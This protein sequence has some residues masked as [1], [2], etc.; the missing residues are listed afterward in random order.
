M[1]ILINIANQRLRLVTNVSSFIA[2]TR[3][4]IRFVFLVSKEME[5]FDITAQFIQNG[6]LY[7]ETLDTDNSV[8]L[9]EEIGVG[10]FTLTLLG[11]SGEKRAV[12]SSLEFTVKANNMVVS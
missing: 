12:T 1:D 11:T 2:G 3:K 7:E 5:G 4:F 9:P 8:Y 10:T 6:T